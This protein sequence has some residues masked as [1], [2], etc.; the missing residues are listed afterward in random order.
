MDISRLPHASHSQ[1]F[2]CH[3]ASNA[4]T[5]FL[6]MYYATVPSYLPCQ[7]EYLLRLE[8]LQPM[9]FPQS[10]YLPCQVQIITSTSG[11]PP[12]YVPP[13]GYEIIFTPV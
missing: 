2:R 11:Q 1:P 4:V 6:G 5:E 13:S 9:Y 12:T 7:Y 8:S 3:L 10:S